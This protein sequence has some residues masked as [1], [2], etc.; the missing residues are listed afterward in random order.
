MTSDQLDAFY[1]RQIEGRLLTGRGKVERIVATSGEGV[2]GKY[3]VEI[4][5]SPKVVV[6]LQTNGFA[7][8]RAGA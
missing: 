5:C 4:M 7:I 6:K 3:E 1:E 2:D 8:E